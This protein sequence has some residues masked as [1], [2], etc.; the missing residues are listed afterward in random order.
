VAALADCLA[1]YF[2]QSQALLGVAEGIQG[3]I[4]VLLQRPQAKRPFSA[5]DIDV[6]VLLQGSEARRLPHLLDELQAL[7]GFGA[8]VTRE[9][10][11]L[12]ATPHHPVPPTGTR[13]PEFADMVS[14]DTR[15]LCTHP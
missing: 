2:L 4:N 15:A 10:I 6:H 9:G 13:S 12:H 5:A 1:Q 3:A 14:A 11:A 8:Q 7:L